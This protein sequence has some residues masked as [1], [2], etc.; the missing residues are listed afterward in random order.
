M[1]LTT[2]QFLRTQP[3]KVKLI[4]FDIDRTLGVGSFG[5]VKLAKIKQNGKFVAMKILR[6]DKMINMKQVDHVLNELRVLTLVDHAFLV[7]STGYT[8]DEKYIYIVLDLVNGGDLFTY[9][10]E[11]VRIPLELA[12]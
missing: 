8:Q 10:R 6:K 5:V 12:T 1:S 2:E 7:K 9:L 4:D 11:K 3:K